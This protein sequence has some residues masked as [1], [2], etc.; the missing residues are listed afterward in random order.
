[1]R[2]SITILRCQPGFRA[3]KTHRKTDEGIKTEDYNA[4]MYFT[5]VAAPV[6][7]IEELSQYI[8]KPLEAHP[9]GLVIRGKAQAHLDHTKWHRRM[10]YAPHANYA[11]PPQGRCYAMV[12]IDRL[13]LPAGMLLTPDTATDAVEYAINRLPHELRTVSYHFQLSS[14]A[15]IY[16]QTVISVHL[17]FWLDR[18]VTDAEMKRWG[19]AANTAAGRVLIDTSLFNDVQPHYTAAPLFEGMRDPFAARSGLIRKANDCASLNIPALTHATPAQPTKKSSTHRGAAPKREHNGTARGFDAHLASIG[20]H[21]GGGGFHDP[22]I[23]AAASYVAEHGADGTDVEWL[24]GTIRARVL[25]ADSTHHAPEEVA[26]RA[27]REH[28]MPAINGAI[29]KFGDKPACKPR[30]IRGLKPYFSAKPVCVEIA[31]NKMKKAVGHFFT[32]W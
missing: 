5:S 2:N 1:M 31:S 4:G 18:P 14:S 6:S 12:D 16:D 17:W 7:G 10:K 20:D 25:A 22:I 29:E 11:T 19:K 15:G 23:R 32:K 27:S 26:A 28:I 24:Y 8:L 30:L 13:P 3:T 21:A 9:S